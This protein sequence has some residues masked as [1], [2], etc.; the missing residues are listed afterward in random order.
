MDTPLDQSTD[1]LAPLH[2][3]A[4]IRAQARKLQAA[5]RGARSLGALRRAADRAEGF[6]LGL[7]TVHALQPIDVK[8]LYV[9]FECAA[10]ARQ[11]ALG[12]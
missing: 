8:N 9:V 4:A 7:E 6:V 10:Q 1:P 5:I 12:R 11:A 3:P 2:L